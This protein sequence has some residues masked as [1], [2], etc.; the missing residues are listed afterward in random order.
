MKARLGAAA[1][2]SAFDWDSG[3]TQPEF[4]KR[5]AKRN[6]P[7][8]N[9]IFAESSSSNRSSQTHTSLELETASSCFLTGL[10]LDADFR[11]LADFV[12]TE[13]E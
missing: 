4:K 11:D 13:A 1:S 5:M 3:I 8:E 10:L 7:L 9:A 2:L 12:V 6:L